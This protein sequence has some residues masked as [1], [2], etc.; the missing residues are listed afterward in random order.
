MKTF[1]LIYFRLLPFS[2]VD[3]I[4]A[5]VAFIQRAETPVNVALSDPAFRYNIHNVAQLKKFKIAAAAVINSA[6]D[7]NARVNFTVFVFV[8][9]FLFNIALSF[10]HLTASEFAAS[11]GTEPHFEQRGAKCAEECCAR[12]HA[13][14]A[15]LRR[16]F[17]CR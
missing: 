7:S 1:S 13:S 16:C 17:H 5:L 10:S 12:F 2:F 11:G 8:S 15:K 3:T 6:G 4:E 9:Y 14:L